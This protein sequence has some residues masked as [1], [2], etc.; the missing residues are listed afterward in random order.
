MTINFI[1]YTL[2]ACMSSRLCS[3]VTWPAVYLRG[4]PT[5][6]ARY[7]TT[8]SEPQT[9]ACDLYVLIMKTYTIR[10][11]SFGGFYASGQGV[12]LQQL[13]DQQ[14]P[15]VLNYLYMHGVKLMIQCRNIILQQTVENIWA[16][17]NVVYLC[18]LAVEDRDIFWDILRRRALWRCW[19]SC[20]RCNLLT[21]RQTLWEIHG[22]L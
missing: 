15:F 10:F 22:H 1:I 16:H 8:G 9:R 7:R 6:P 18:E 19:R 14:L 17:I 21:Q 11:P 12:C 3:H 20:W 4:R 13:R 5:C 2:L